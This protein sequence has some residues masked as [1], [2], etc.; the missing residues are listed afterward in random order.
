MFGCPE[1]VGKFIT[2]AMQGIWGFLLCK[3]VIFK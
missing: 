2:M 1:V 3:F